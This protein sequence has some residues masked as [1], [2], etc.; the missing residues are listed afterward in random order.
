[1]INNQPSDLRQYL[2]TLA[3]QLKEGAQT[4]VEVVFKTCQLIAMYAADKSKPMPLDVFAFDLDDNIA[5]LMLASS[6]MTAIRTAGS[7][8]MQQRAAKGH[9]IT[10][11]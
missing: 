4:E 8:Q 3:A 5:R 7:L 2:N 6:C 9:I 11:K 1:M 10:P